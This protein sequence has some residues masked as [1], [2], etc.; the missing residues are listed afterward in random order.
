LC[1]R[2]LHD[3]LHPPKKYLPFAKLL[4]PQFYSLAVPPTIDTTEQLFETLKILSQQY[5]LRNTSGDIPEDF[6]PSLVR[7][8]QHILEKQTKRLDSFADVILAAALTYVYLFL[9]QIPGNAGIY[10]RISPR[11]QM[12]LEILLT[13]ESRSFS[14]TEY[15]ILLW[16]VFMGAIPTRGTLGM[17]QTSKDQDES[18][19]WWIKQLCDISAILHLK[20]LSDFEQVLVEVVNITLEG[21]QWCKILWSEM[22]T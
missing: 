5:A 21:K 2:T 17:K 8:E 18:R 16:T 19:S 9:R 3:E 4:P 13:D 15:C 20:S 12:S 14:D 6:C 22:K 7:L 10:L 11:I 1:S